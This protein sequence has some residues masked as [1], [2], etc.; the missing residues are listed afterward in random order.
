MNAGADDEKRVEMRRSM[1]NTLRTEG[2]HAIA[3]LLEGESQP[4]LINGA[5]PDIVGFNET[6]MGVVVQVETCNTV[7]SLEAEERLTSLVEVM[8]TGYEFRLLVPTECM[9]SAVEWIRRLGLDE[10]IVWEYF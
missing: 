6:G 3:A 9:D 1:C 7:A 2:Y 5:Q 4:G 8:A 10:D